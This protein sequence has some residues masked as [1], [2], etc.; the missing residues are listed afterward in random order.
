[1]LMQMKNNE[2]YS[3]IGKIFV[4]AGGSCSRQITSDSM[5]KEK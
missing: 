2:N 1:M 3:E 4:Y 5:S